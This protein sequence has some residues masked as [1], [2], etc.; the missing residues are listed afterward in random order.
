ML[1]VTAFV[2][3]YTVCLM[4]KYYYDLHIHS[5][6]SPCG[7]NDMTPN[8]IAGMASL[9]GLQIVALTDHNTCKN[10]PAFL[11]ACKKNG[12]VGIPGME[13][14]TAEEIHLL[15]LFENLDNAMAF[16]EQVEKHRFKIK[17][18]P[19]IFGEQLILDAD[20]N[21]CGC[22]ENLL[23]NATMLDLDSA[24]DLAREHGAF[25]CPAHVDKQ[26]NGIIGILGTFPKSPDFGYA[27]LSDLSKSD[28]LKAEH[29]ELAK[30]KLLCN[31]DAHYLWDI[32]EAE[33]YIVLDDE[34]YSSK[35]V[36]QELFKI[37]LLKEQ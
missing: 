24:V 7:D 23:I 37:L 30:C 6:L 31:S 20:D 12:I 5:C 35:K 21:I 32:H 25:V 34:P 10:C 14:T 36:R 8:N 19:E 13:L 18:R 3:L 16:S 22:E 11:D 28:N 15:C 29:T 17:N 26:S 2:P 9:K 27:E 1:T 4:N 33:N